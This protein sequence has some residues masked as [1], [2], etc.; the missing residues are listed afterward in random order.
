MPWVQTS[1]FT[2][3]KSDWGGE[4]EGNKN[5][6]EEKELYVAPQVC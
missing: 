4:Q 2:T 6:C 1:E 3:E 5:F